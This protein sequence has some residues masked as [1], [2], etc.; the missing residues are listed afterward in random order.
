MVD[1]IKYRPIIV[2]STQE[3]AHIH[4]VQQ[5]L[6][7]QMLLVET[8]VD[9]QNRLNFTTSG[10]DII[11]FYKDREIHNPRSIWY[12]KP[13][14]L[15]P[16]QL[17]VA[18][19]H[20]DYSRSAL[21][22]HLTAWYSL[23]PDAL[24]VSDYYAIQRADRKPAQ[25]SVASR[26]GFRVPETLLTSDGEMARDFV[27]K[28]GR[29]VVKTLAVVPALSSDNM[30]MKFFTRQ[31]SS[32]EDTDFSGLYL[33]PAIFQ[34]EI[35]AVREVRVTVVGNKVFAAAITTKGVDK[36]SPFR[37]YKVA[38]FEPNAKVIVEPYELPDDLKEKCI[39]YTKTF[40]LK[41]CAIDLL[42]DKKGKLWFLEGNPNGQWAFVEEGTGYP[43]GETI[44]E[45]LMSN[46]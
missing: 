1:A 14:P 23:F 35:D 4:Y 16:D 12:R 30:I 27:K 28:H 21:T 8:R 33:A 39:A 37:D 31:I 44:A 34:K 3:D 13:L 20:L 32:K 25:L 11:M 15:D 10:G 19:Q 5:H 29:C 18:K 36:K 38:Y 22:M 17:P 42:E 46:K 9:P 2:I 24:W 7:E 41:F 40:N 26:L 6:P 45:L 43:I